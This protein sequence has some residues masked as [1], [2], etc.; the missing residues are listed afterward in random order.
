MLMYVLSGKTSVVN[1]TNLKHL[2]QLPCLTYIRILVTMETSHLFPVVHSPHGGVCV[3]Q[4]AP[5]M[6]EPEVGALWER[7]LITTGSSSMNG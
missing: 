5:E 2:N 4:S 3:S 7:E 1:F 6:R